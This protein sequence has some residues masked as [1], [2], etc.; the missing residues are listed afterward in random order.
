MKYN[1]ELLEE[2]DRIEESMREYPENRIDVDFELDLVKTSDQHG[3]ACWT[4]T[5]YRTVTI[6]YYLP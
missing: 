5:G 6:K 3:V 1:K 4:P 2:L